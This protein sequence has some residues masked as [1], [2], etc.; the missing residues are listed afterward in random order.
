MVIIYPLR[1]VITEQELFAFANQ[2]LQL[3]LSCW[4]FSDH[5]AGEEAGWGGAGLAWLHMVCSFEATTIAKFSEATL[6]HL[7]THGQ[8]LRWT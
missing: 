2:L 1:L 7:A 6:E 5:H 4:L 8:Q 3:L